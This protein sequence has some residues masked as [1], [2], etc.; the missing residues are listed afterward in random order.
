MAKKDSDVERLEREN[1]ELKRTNRHLLKQLKKVN[2]GYRK[3]RED[4]P[5]DDFEDEIEEE[6]KVRCNKCNS[7]SITQTSF[8]LVNGKV[9][10]L[11]VC[12][13]CGHRESGERKND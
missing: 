5:Q 3:I 11:K 2:K 10:T 12:S 7:K 4:E 8:T 9:K 13:E 6:H 1:R